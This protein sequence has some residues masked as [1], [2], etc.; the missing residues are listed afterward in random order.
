MTEDEAGEVPAFVIRAVP[1]WTDEELRRGRR[2]GAVGDNGEWI[3]E[4]EPEDEDEAEVEPVGED[5]GD[6]RPD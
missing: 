1:P 5:D 2:V 4:G 3:P 6:A